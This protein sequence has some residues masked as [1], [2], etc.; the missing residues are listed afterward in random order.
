[1]A[2]NAVTNAARDVIRNTA[3]NVIRN[4]AHNVITNTANHEAHLSQTITTRFSA[5]GSTGQQ[6]TEGD[7]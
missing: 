3:H 4:T 1:M 2:I 7:V 6:N 5:S